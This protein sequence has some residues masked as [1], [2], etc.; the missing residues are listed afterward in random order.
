MHTT[1]EKICYQFNRDKC[2]G[3]FEKTFR[4][5]PLLSLFVPYRS[6]RVCMHCKIIIF[7]DVNS[8]TMHFAFSRL[9]LGKVLKRSQKTRFACTQHAL[10]AKWGNLLVWIPI[11]HCHTSRGA[12][13][14]IIPS[15]LNLNF[16]GE[17]GRHFIAKRRKP[18]RQWHDWMKKK[19]L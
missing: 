4:S 14:S 9:S 1:E 11:R 6:E 15:L 16:F 12:F 13:L 3:L 7:C 18:Y 2:F 17:S 19:R 5:M 10:N 8:S